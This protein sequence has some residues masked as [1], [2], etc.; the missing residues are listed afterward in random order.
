MQENTEE[1]A[2]TKTLSATCR[3]TGALHCSRRHGDDLGMASP[4]A[5]DRQTQDG[6]PYKWSDYVHKVSSIVLV[7][8]VDAERGSSK[9]RYT[10]Y[11]W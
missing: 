5:E 6:T 10:D 7:R 11:M 9:R 8:H 4:S 2:H 3:S 1:H